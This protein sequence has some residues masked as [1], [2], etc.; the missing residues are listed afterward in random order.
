M[1]GV[2]GQVLGHV[3]RRSV[4][5]YSDQKAQEDMNQFFAQHQLPGWAV[6]GIALYAIFFA[7]A[8]ASIRYT[9]GDVIATLMMVETPKTE[10]I[11]TISEP[12]KSADPD[13]PLEKEDYLL[14]T[15]TVTIRHEPV[16]KTGR[17]TMRH[18]VKHAGSFSRWRGL[19]VSFVYHLCVGAVLSLVPRHQPLLQ[20][21][22]STLAT[23]MFSRIHMTWTHV[24][25]SMPSE[26][27]W[28]RR[29][30][31][32][33]MQR[34]VL[35]PSAVYAAAQ[36]LTIYMPM[37]LAV[38]LGL[39]RVNHQQLVHEFTKADRVV[40][41]VKL[42]ACLLTAAFVALT[43]LLPASVTL[44]R[45]EASMLPEEDE[46]LVP[47]DRTFDGK[48]VPAI[49]GGTG[50]VSFVDAWRT[51]D[52]KVRFR[53]VKIYAQL[54]TMQTIIVILGMI[55]LAAFA[56]GIKHIQSGH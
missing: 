31:S 2:H 50:C 16:T 9:I 22:V 51:V 52:R 38:V 49:V 30:P 43:V 20:G 27:T 19:S 10:T 17:S 39:H 24:L 1:T 13:A 46:A 12:A 18:M 25:I 36:Q 8:L 41:A 26:K 42:G 55:G 56:V 40:Y 23:V 14:D 47:F 34:N 15:E 45:I 21:A 5:A 33:K 44:T 29:M 11:T 6:A 3:V 53:I 54:F 37:L 32:R 4:E 48:V 28:F 7:V 35:L